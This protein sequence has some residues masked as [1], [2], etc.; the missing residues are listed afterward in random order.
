MKVWARIKKGM[1][2]FG[3][4]YR[5]GGKFFSRNWIIPEEFFLYVLLR[6]KVYWKITCEIQLF[7][8]YIDFAQFFDTEQNSSVPGRR[9]TVYLNIENKVKSNFVSISFSNT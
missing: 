9:Y 3:I 1:S 7:T 4:I 2:K 5:Y 6:Y 8:K